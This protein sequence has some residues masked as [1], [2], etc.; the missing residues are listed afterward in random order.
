[1]KSY[2]ELISL[3]DFESRFDYLKLSGSVCAPTFGS[4]RYLNQ[5]FYRSPEWRKFRR[6]IIFR[7]NGCDLGIEDRPIHGKILIHHIVPITD[8]DIYRR[9]VALLDSENVIT[10][11]FNTHQAIHYGD[12]S[13]VC[14]DIVPERHK[15]DTC[16]WK[17]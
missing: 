17:E 11:S 15:N 3:R 2:S 4:K 13:M 14:P 6:D 1:M 7:D 16:P 12:S 9:D 10:V 8:E 5:L